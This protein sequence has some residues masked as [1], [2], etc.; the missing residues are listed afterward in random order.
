M[1]WTLTKKGYRIRHK[2]YKIVLPFIT[3]PEP[4]LIAGAGSTKTLA[5]KISSLGIDNLLIVTDKVLMELGMLE[6][7][8]NS[9]KENQI[10]YSIFDDVQPNPTIQNVE[11]GLEQYKTNQCAGI[12]AFG[13]G[14]P[15]DC[16][17]IIGARVKNPKKTIL[18]MKGSFK[19]KKK[20]PPLFA[21]PTTSGTGSETTAGA[22]ITDPETHEKFGIISFK[23]VPQIA[24]LDP[25]LTLG[26]PP[27]ITSTTGIDALT[28]AIEAY[29][30]VATNDAVIEASEKA[31][32]LLFGNLEDVYKDGSDIEKRNNVALASF[33]AGCAITRSN[34]GY[35][36][37]IAHNMGGLYGV[38]HGMANAIILPYILEFSQKDA[39]EKLANLAVAAGIGKQGESSK[40]LSHKFIESVKELNRNMDLPST[41]K[42]L[43]EK[44]IPLIVE[45]TLEEA[46]PNYPVPTIMN[47]KECELVLNK[48]LA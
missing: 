28:H 36:H 38:P 47:P 12:I 20:I 4:E 31:V 22:I 8:M 37:A 11:N 10:S 39:E 17:K 3:F 27:H 33:Y 18:K 48:L 46:N 6:N 21:I 9:L 24:V 26:L 16:A 32:K 40:T 30:G 41:I 19:L 1:I 35:V 44:D 2:I 5:K 42:E 14:S 45:R 43:Q 7:L 25:E 29:I 15:M 23:V 34:V 13:G